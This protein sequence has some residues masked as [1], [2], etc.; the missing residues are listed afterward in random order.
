MIEFGMNAENPFKSIRTDN[1]TSKFNPSIKCHK[2]IKYFRSFCACL[3]VWFLPLEF[4]YTR[5]GHYF[6]SISSIG[7][8]GKHS[9]AMKFLSLLFSIVSCV[10]YKPQCLGRKERSFAW[11][12][13]MDGFQ[14]NDAPNHLLFVFHLLQFKQ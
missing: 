5:C 12:K 11:N 6:R 2:H 3:G 9:I 8:K 1:K 4:A 13:E 14:L 10:V 7:I